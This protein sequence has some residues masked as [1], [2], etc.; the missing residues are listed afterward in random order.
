MPH[1]LLLTRPILGFGSVLGA[2]LAAA[3]AS[4]QSGDFSISALAG[5]ITVAIIAICGTIVAV[6]P[7]I[8][9]AITKFAQTVGP[10]LLELQK[11][12][13][14]IKKGTYTGQIEELKEMLTE[15]KEDYAEAKE[16]LAKSEAERAERDK[17]YAEWERASQEREER[18][19]E[20][21]QKARKGLHEIRDK[22]GTDILAR[23]VKIMELEEVINNLRLEIVRLTKI[24]EDR[25]D[26]QDRKIADNTAD[27]KSLA[28]HQKAA[29]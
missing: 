20:S 7:V 26:A 29:S 1:R 22:L 5:G 28:E 27:I 13:E 3:Y 19:E 2:N 18:L 17:K 25:T 6:S 12:R 11:Q 9:G 21:L 10:A 23:D 24:I 8:A 15:L 14:E 16:E 4:V